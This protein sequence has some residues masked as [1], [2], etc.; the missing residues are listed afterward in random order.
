[1]LR[2][3]PL[4]LVGKS[5]VLNLLSVEGIREAHLEGLGCYGSNVVVLIQA[6]VEE[7][8]AE[9]EEG[10]EGKKSGATSDLPTF[11]IG[12]KLTHRGRC[13]GQRMC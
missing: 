7:R 5:G 13:F 4:D 11:R 3:T 1:M 9:E 6:M 8:A 2:P 12:R 10:Q